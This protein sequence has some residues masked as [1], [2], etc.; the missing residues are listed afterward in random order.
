MKSSEYMNDIK[1]LIDAHGVEETLTI[2]EEEASELIKALTKYKRARSH[3]EQMRRK[4]EAMEEMADVIICIDMLMTLFGITERE[5]EKEIKKK[6]E[7][8]LKRIYN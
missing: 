8:N 4:G 2:C 6:M 5:L 7:R 1:I 3:S